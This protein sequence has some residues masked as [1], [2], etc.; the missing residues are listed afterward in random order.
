M[1]KASIEKNT[2]WTFLTNHSHVLI[3]LTANPNKVLREVALEVGITERNV[4]RIVADLEEAGILNRERDGRRNR[5]TIHR[6]HTLRHPLESHVE[7]GALLDF[8]LTKE[9][10]S[11]EQTS[12]VQ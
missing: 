3:C 8:I 9:D 10:S 2:H 7:I 11:I 12:T 1:S 4:Q 5:Y 6:T